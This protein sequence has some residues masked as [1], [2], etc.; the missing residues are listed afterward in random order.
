MKSEELLAAYGEDV[1]SDRDFCLLKEVH[2]IEIKLLE[3]L[4][5]VEAWLHF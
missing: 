1:Q 2:L 4:G 5:L 3:F